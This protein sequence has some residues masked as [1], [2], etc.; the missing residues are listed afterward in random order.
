MKIKV[1]QLLL[2]AVILIIATITL[3]SIALK[4]NEVQV[5]DTVQ[6]VKNETIE[7]ENEIKEEV[8]NTIP[9]NNTEKTENTESIVDG[10]DETSS[11]VSSELLPLYKDAIKG[12]RYY[13]YSSVPLDDKAIWLN[14]DTKECSLSIFN[15]PFTL[16]G[17]FEKKGNTYICKSNTAEAEEVSQ[18]IDEIIVTLEKNENVINI[19]KTSRDAVKIH[20]IDLRDNSLMDD[21]EDM[22]IAF[23][24]N[25]KMDFVNY[26]KIIMDTYN[27]YKEV[28]DYQ[29]SN[30]GP[31][32]NILVKLGLSTEK[33]IKSEIDAAKVQNSNTY[34]KSNVK[35]E[36]FKAKMLEMMTEEYFEEYYSDYKNMDGFVGYCNCGGGIIPTTI[37][38][39]LSGGIDDN[40]KTFTFNLLE[41]DDELYSHFEDGEIGDEAECYF[42]KTIK[43]VL[44]E[45]GSLLLSK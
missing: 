33:Q 7:P 43:A 31:M 37:L 8:E 9:E 40:E 44:S 38:G 21:T 4:N 30:I 28:E 24:K 1:Y 26:N 11:K 14:E 34:I 19:V 2:I 15:R 25:E 22:N 35:Y 27:K 23:Y 36:D 29:N 39:V 42:I 10:E 17:T 41:R 20:F 13:Y 32:P 45:D 6:E 12:D 5:I 3:I 18:P 16:T